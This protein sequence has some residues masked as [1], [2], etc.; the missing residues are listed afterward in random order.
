MALLEVVHFWGLGCKKPLP[1]LVDCFCFTFVDQDV[2]FQLLYQ[3]QAYL[4][5]AMFLTVL[6]MDSTTSWTHGPQLNA[7]FYKLPWLW[8]F[9][10][11]PITKLRVVAQTWEAETSLVYRRRSKTAKDI[12][13]NLV[14]KHTSFKTKENKTETEV[15][16]LWLWSCHGRLE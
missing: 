16:Y 8:Y 14:L 11:A 12:E 9:I 1:H 4:L 3:H 6:V 5:E 2:S 10:T 13:R 15:W 7:C